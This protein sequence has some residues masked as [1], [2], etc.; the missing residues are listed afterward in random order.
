MTQEQ[1]TKELSRLAYQ[2]YTLSEPTVSD[3]EYDE[4]YDKLA[5]MERESGRVLPGSPTMRVGS[6]PLP[7]FEKHRHIAPLYSLDKA[8][9]SGEVR[10]FMD[11]VRRTDPGALF[12]LEYKFD[13]LTINLTYDDHRLVQ[14]ST[15]GDGEVGEGVLAQAA[16]IKT[17]PMYIP[18]AGKMEVQGEAIM[19]LSALE[20]YNEKADEPLKNARNAAAGAL[21]NLDPKETARRGLDAFFYNVGYIEGKDF[22]THTEMINFLKE[23]GFVVSDF[24]RVYSEPEELL[25]ALDEAEAKRDELDF[26]ID[27]MV[28]KT[29]DMSL[30]DELGYTQKFPRWAVAYKFEAQEMTTRVL[31]VNWDVGRTGKLTP[32]A[33]LEEV[34]I[35]GASV[36]RATLNNYQDILRK[37]V[38]LGGRVFVRRSNDVIPEVLGSCEENDALDVPEMPTVCPACGT[39][40]EEIGPNLFCPNT[41]SC[42]PQLVAAIVHFASKGAMNID[43]LSEKTAQ[44]L[45]DKL[46]IK[47]IASLYKLTKEQLLSLDGFLD[48]KAQNLMDAIERSKT[49]ELDCF[50]YALGIQNVGKKT[51]RDL[52]EKYGSMEAL[53]AASADELAE[54]D[55]VGDVVA[56]GIV[57]FFASGQVRATLRELEELGVN[58]RQLEKK[59]GVFSG[60]TVVLT[61]KLT[62]FTRGQAQEKI[63][64]MGGSVG[65]GV[66]KAT[67]LV[68]AGEKAGSKLVKAEKLGVKVINEAQFLELI[69]D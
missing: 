60:K 8:K 26:L 3:A 51:A 42:R 29:D 65:S 48:K 19:K 7:G 30:R 38:K 20:K 50:I 33:I 43:G 62:L 40:L 56:M 46:E 67:D 57:D 44:L 18:F 5:A 39:A 24:E 28:I 25:S 9:T 13:G 41:L 35:G 68:V 54:I 23:N 58:P 16:T 59:E 55:G 34:E 22:D 15:R 69:G 45:F 52:A 36:K 53:S 37:R 2:Y 11:R 10:E 32:V 12:T 66:T 47:D 49:P 17:I 21:R 1:L 14:A 64:S 63:E 27:G 6:Q 4:M 61:G 31:D